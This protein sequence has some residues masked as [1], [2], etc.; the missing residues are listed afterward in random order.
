[1][2]LRQQVCCNMQEK[3]AMIIVCSAPKGK[4]SLWIIQHHHCRWFPSP[5]QSLDCLEPSP[6][7][8]FKE[9]VHISSPDLLSDFNIVTAKWVFSNHLR[10][11]ALPLPYLLQYI[12][13]GLF[14]SSVLLFP[15]LS[16]RETAGQEGMAPGFWDS[17]T[18]LC[19]K[20]KRNPLTDSGQPNTQL[21]GE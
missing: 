21:R 15:D 8:N 1:M 18:P 16:H 12:W 4:G 11:D 2:Y 6:E 9:P 17:I 20:C 19:K 14:L 10:L 5:K 7:W 13:S 3:P